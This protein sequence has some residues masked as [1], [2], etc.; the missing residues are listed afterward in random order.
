MKEF[1]TNRGVLLLTNAEQ[2]NMLSSLDK[3]NKNFYIH[4]SEKSEKFFKIDKSQYKG[5]ETLSL[6]NHFFVNWQ[7]T[8]QASYYKVETLLNLLELIDQKIVTYDKVVLN[9]NW[10]QSRSPNVAM[11]YL[12]KRTNFFEKNGKTKLDF[13]SCRKE[14]IKLYPDYLTDSGIG[15]FIERYW[16]ELI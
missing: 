10:A 6:L 16:D 12:A 13:T 7:D 5:L 4:I 14:F 1:I 11:T 15:L 2:S 8:N 3:D 9:C